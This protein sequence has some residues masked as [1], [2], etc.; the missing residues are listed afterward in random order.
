MLVTC[1]WLRAFVTE[2]PN[3]DELGQLLTDIGLEVEGHSIA[4]PALDGIV[5]GKILAQDTPS[6]NTPRRWIVDVGATETL[7]IVCT[8]TN[9]R[10]GK[11]VAIALPGT[12][13]GD[14]TIIS[15]DIG[16]IRSEAMMCSAAELELGEDRDTLLELGRD[17][18]P[19]ATLNGLLETDDQVFDLAVTP[20]RGDWLSIYGVAR[21]IAAKCALRLRDPKF[22]PSQSAHADR[23]KLQQVY[24]DAPEACPKFACL[25]ISQV[26]TTV[27][28][29]PLISQRLRYCGVRPVSIIVDLT[30]YVMLELGQPLHAFDHSRLSGDLHV[31]FARAG[32]TLKLL[33]GTKVQLKT[34]HLLV[35]DQAGPQAIAGVMGG[36][37]SSVTAATTDVLLEAAHFVPQIIRGRTR[38]LNISSEAAFRFERGVN[39]HLCELALQ[40]TAKLIKRYCGGKIGGLTVAGKAPK[41]ATAVKLADGQTEQLTGMAVPMREA[42]RRLKALGFTVATQR[43][44]LQV[45]SPPW[46]FDVERKEDLIEEIIR[47]GGYNALPVTMPQLTASF[48]A[49]PAKRLD[50]QLARDRL[51]QDGY[52]E[53]ITYAF[54]PPQ[55]EID[56]YANTQPFQLINPL[57]EELSVM[58]SGLLGG[59]LDR[60]IYNQRRR[61]ERLR[62]FEIGRCFDAATDTQPLRLAGLGWGK[63]GSTLWSTQQRSY[64]LF[65]AHGSLARLLPGA[66]LDMV[67]LSDHPA[68]H[69]HRAATVLHD[70][71]PLGIVGEIHPSLLE[72]HRYALEP[73]PVVF[74]LELDSLLQQQHQFRFKPFSKLPLV[75]RDLAVIVA[76]EITSA[77]LL[78]S[79]AAGVK[80]AEFS[81]IADIEI[82]DSFSG[83]SIAA[84][85]RSVGLR[86]VMQGSFAN[87]V[88]EQINAVMEAIATRLRDDYQAEVRS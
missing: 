5:A 55:W 69:P 63:V 39:P 9:A 2:L 31:R 82:F 20:N 21:E 74:E 87:L 80:F 66:T 71:Q 77:Q 40:Q 86:I 83:D 15:R 68:L 3:A 14:H 73:A 61:Q 62:L 84:G 70:G 13:L 41:P 22:K 1:N 60:A 18:K 16:G 56:F 4:G 79:A 11:R 37:A 42:K 28:T 47:F 48:A 33:D 85:K 76:R 6:A 38:E 67:S 59:L 43:K 57:A 36:M 46:R 10:K 27:A 45:T 58:R 23:S 44:L 24:L 32:E 81:E 72:K 19:G 8:A 34:S 35:A 75:R 64:D 12:K 50:T 52:Q 51:V 25:P 30:N 17:A 29:P 54:V 7:R 53:I 78:K 65:D 88:D 26:N 49:A